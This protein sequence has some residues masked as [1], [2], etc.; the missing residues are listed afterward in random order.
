VSW[1]YQHLHGWIRDERPFARRLLCCSSSGWTVAVSG[2][3]RIVWLV[4]LQGTLCKAG[5]TMASMWSNT[6][7]PNLQVRCQSVS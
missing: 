3:A 7:L 6:L 4:I 1:T 2:R 5:N